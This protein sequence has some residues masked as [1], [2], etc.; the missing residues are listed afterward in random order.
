M[1]NFVEVDRV[2]PGG[3]IYPILLNLD[4]VEFMERAPK[5]TE[6]ILVHFRGSKILI[7]GDLAQYAP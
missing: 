1:S 5:T 7:I 2:T 3:L 4:Q 6:C